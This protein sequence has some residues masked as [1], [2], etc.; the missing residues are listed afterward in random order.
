MTLYTTMLFFGALAFYLLVQTP[1]I[2]TVARILAGI[3]S[4]VLCVIL[5]LGQA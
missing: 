3:A 2:K 5:I 4:A 1:E